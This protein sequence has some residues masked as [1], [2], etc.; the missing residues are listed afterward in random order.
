MSPSSFFSALR[1]ARWHVAKILYVAAG[2]FLLVFWSGCVSPGEPVTLAQTRVLKVS[3]LELMGKAV[4][5]YPNH[6]PEITAQN[7]KLEAAY[8]H[9]RARF[10]NGSSTKM[11]ATLLHADSQLPGSGIY[12]RFLSQWQKKGVLSP[13][14]IE[15]KKQNVGEAFDQILSLEAAKPTR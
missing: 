3:T 11:W 10:G 7:A 13:I 5:P 1:L 6:L 2:A 4:E 8:D 9:E 14:Y 12:G 15:D